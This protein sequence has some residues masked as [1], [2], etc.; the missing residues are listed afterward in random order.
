MK[1]DWQDREKL[2][3]AAMDGDLSRVKQLVESGFDVNSFDEGL[4]YTPLHYAAKAEFHAVASY[5]LAAGADVNAHETP[6]GAV[7]ASCSYEIAKLLA[8]AG[9]NPTIAGWMGDMSLWERQRPRAALPGPNGVIRDC[10]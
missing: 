7:A 10:S 3:F 1:H 8:D 4:G 2:H 5:L 9:A 6:L